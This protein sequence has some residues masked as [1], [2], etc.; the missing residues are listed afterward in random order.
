MDG[1][2][3]ASHKARNCL[4]SKAK[5]KPTH[6][7]LRP[8]R[9]HQSKWIWAC[10]TETRGEVKMYFFRSRISTP[11]KNKPYSL[12]CLRAESIIF[13]RKL[14]KWLKGGGLGFFLLIGPLEIPSPE[15]IFR[16]SPGRSGVLEVSSRHAREE[17]HHLPCA[18]PYY[19]HIDSCSESSFLGA[20]SYSLVRKWEI[21]PNFIAT[22]MGF[23]FFF[24][25]CAGG[26]LL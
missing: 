19:I 4:R 16:L 18:V 15:K 2:L 22:T 5:R 13:L 23:G 24:P 11:M 26:R 8:C 12:E 9:L 14:Q 1:A 21:C 25:M 6:K 10:T 20:G 3:L 7:M 17:P